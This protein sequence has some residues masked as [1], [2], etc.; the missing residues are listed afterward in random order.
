MAETLFDLT[1]FAPPA[2]EWAKDCFYCSPGDDGYYDEARHFHDHLP[3]TC[4][5]CRQTSPNRLLFE[6]SHCVNLGASWGQN[7]LLCSSL[8]LRLNHLLYDARAGQEPAERDL[9]ALEL[10]WRVDAN[11]IYMPEGWPDGSHAVKCE[12]VAL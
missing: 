7:A 3:L 6:M 12:A 5:V 1:D 9:T 4:A 10:G 8:S 11:G 2:P